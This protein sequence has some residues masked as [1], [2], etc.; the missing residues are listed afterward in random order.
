[1]T[2]VNHE[3]FG[4]RAGVHG[5]L[6]GVRGPGVAGA[7]PLAPRRKLLYCVCTRESVAGYVMY[8]SGHLRRLLVLAS[9]QIKSHETVARFE[10]F[11]TNASIK[12]QGGVRVWPFDQKLDNGPDQA[13][14]WWLPVHLGAAAG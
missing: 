7:R 10:L 3:F 4:L 14:Q 2:A 12:R 9:G 5:L 8:A 11:S 1:M 13:M 6:F